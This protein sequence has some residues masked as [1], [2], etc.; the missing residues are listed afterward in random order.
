MLALLGI[1]RQ[2]TKGDILRYVLLPQVFPRVRDLYKS[3][4]SNLAY[5]IAQVYRGVRILPENHRVFSPQMRSHLTIRHVMAAAAAE[6]PS[7]STS[8]GKARSLILTTSLR[9]PS[10]FPSKARLTSTAP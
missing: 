1:T 6:L 7:R 3:G 2:I 4:F 8:R 5:L 10:S 9:V